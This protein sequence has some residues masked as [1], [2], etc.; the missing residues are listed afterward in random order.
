[1]SDSRTAS[2]RYQRA[3]RELLARNGTAEET[4]KSKT[5]ESKTSPSETKLKT[6]T[7]QTNAY[8]KSTNTSNEGK[9]ELFQIFKQTSV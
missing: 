2:R 8:P 4:V 1:M 3:L 6:T 7:L 5:S 9:I